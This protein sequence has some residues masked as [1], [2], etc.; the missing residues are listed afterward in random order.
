MSSYCQPTV[1]DS[2]PPELYGSVGADTTQRSG[3]GFSQ[4]KESLAAGGSSP[5]SV[6]TSAYMAL[7]D[8]EREPSNE[9]DYI[10]AE[11]LD[12]MAAVAPFQP[13]G[14]TEPRK[15]GEEKMRENEY[16]DTGSLQ[17]AGPVCAG[18]GGGRGER[19][20]TKNAMYENHDFKPLL[21]PALTGT[22][23]VGIYIHL[24]THGR[25]S[26]HSPPNQT[27]LRG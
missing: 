18:P 9:Y 21:H 20:V 11:V 25:S 12:S 8:Q 23:K 2:H 7:R 16:D 24:G 13:P 1:F 15:A 4:G 22:E 10:P 26:G 6:A 27:H 17:P 19:K 5:G 3:G 14:A